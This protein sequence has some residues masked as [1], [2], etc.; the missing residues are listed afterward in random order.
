MTFNLTKHIAL[1]I[2]AAAN[3]AA[4][5]FSSRNKE[6]IGLPTGDIEGFYIELSGLTKVAGDSVQR[7]ATEVDTYV[8]CYPASRSNPLLPRYNILYR[9]SC[10]ALCPSSVC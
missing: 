3:K 2:N 1:P 9:R 4:S 10:K 6:V 5:V 8:A 7:F